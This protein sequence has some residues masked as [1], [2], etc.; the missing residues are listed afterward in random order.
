MRAPIKNH[1]FT[2][3]QIAEL[4]GLQI[5]AQTI[6]PKRGKNASCNPHTPKGGLP[7]GVSNSASAM[8]RQWT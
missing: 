3:R 5:F 8:A 6:F 2:G 7:I 1:K 4:N